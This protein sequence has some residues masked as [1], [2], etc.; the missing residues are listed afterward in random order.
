MIRIKRLLTIAYIF[1]LLAFCLNVRVSAEEVCAHVN[2][3]TAN[4]IPVSCTES[5]YSGD[6]V[7]VKCGEV[8]AKGHVISATGHSFENGVCKICHVSEFEATSSATEESTEVSTETTTEATTAEKSEEITEVPAT[9]KA[10][11]SE[12]QAVTNP[13][14]QPKQSTFDN[15]LNLPSEV[16]IISLILGI[17][18]LIILF[19]ISKM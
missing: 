5:G 11:S 17:G 2:K 1:I 13:P 9:T 16:F 3:K 10:A 7:C 14:S 6:I 12:S 19:C 18:F 4:V 8:L 15:L